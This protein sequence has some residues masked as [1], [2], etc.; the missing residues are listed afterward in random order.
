[1]RIPTDKQNSENDNIRLNEV[2][3]EKINIEQHNPKG[4][5]NVQPNSLKRE[6]DLFMLT[7]YDA[8]K[9]EKHIIAINNI[10][11]YTI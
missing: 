4:I 1:M 5:K 9:K 11:S 3:G 10:L 8:M 7:V 6:A 2:F